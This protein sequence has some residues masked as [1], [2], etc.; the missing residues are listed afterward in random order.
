MG[1]EEKLLFGENFV[2]TQE[3]SRIFSILRSDDGSSYE[4]LLN[5]NR[6]AI[7]ISETP[8]YLETKK[9]SI[10]EFIEVDLELFGYKIEKYLH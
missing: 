4:F 3:E 9:D 1:I 6:C 8:L 7:C 10:R 5:D 2:D